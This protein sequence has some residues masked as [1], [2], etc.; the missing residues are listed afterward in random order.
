MAES[1]EPPNYGV[2]V[3]RSDP[4]L[5]AYKAGI[6]EFDVLLEV[7]GKRMESNIDFVRATMEKDPG[8]EVEIK[9]WSRGRTRTV[10]VELAARSE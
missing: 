9:V 3:S 5:P 2:V 1:G 8:E 10:N 6:R 7:D 4:S